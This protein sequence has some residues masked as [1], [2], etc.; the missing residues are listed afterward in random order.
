MAALDPDA[1][2]LRFAQPKTVSFRAK[3]VIFHPGE[4]IQ[5]F[6][7]AIYYNAA[8]FSVCFTYVVNSKK[9]FQRYWAKKKLFS[10]DSK[11]GMNFLSYNFLQYMAGYML[12]QILN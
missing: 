8:V 10:E 3:W 1:S 5:I 7:K 9:R 11:Y 12:I 4:V 2:L 6:S